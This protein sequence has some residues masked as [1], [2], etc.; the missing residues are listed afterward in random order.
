MTRQLFADSGQLGET[1]LATLQTAFAH[2]PVGIGVC[3]PDGSFLVANK[4]LE[5]L[6]G[7]RHEQIVGR[8]F[9]SFVH[10]EERA[11]CLAAYFISVVGAQT[12]PAHHGARAE[13]RF[14]T[15]QGN[16]VWLA[17]DWAITRP[18]EDGD[19]YGIVH[20]C[21]ITERREIERQ[22]ARARR[23]F[24]LAFDCAPI[25]IAVIGT[26]GR[27]VQANGALRTMLGYEDRE[28]EQTSFAELC[29]PSERAATL[30][31]FE[32]LVSGDLDMHE[33]VKRFRHLAGHTLQTRQV[34]A[35]AREP[36]GEDYLLV[37]IED[38]STGRHAAARLGEL[39]V[40]DPAT[41]LPT[42]RV[43]AAQLALTLH[44]P[45]SLVLIR[46][47]EPPDPANAPEYEQVLTSVGA[48]LTRYC[49]DGDLIAR[50]G[51]LEFAVV[52]E[53]SRATA[54]AT[55]AHR[56]RAALSRPIGSGR[57]ATKLKAA[58]SIDIDRAGTR[59]LE[60]MLQ[61]ARQADPLSATQPRPLANVTMLGTPGRALALD[62][63]LAEALREGQ[64]HLAYQPI[65]RVADRR[66]H[67]LEALSRWQHPALGAISPTEFI[68]IAERSSAIHTLT[69]WALET[70]C[71]DLVNWQAAH[72][73]AAALSVS[74][75][76]SALSFAR[77]DFPDVVNDCLTRTSLPAQQLILEIT[78]TA[79]AE[80]A[81]VLLG[82][83]LRLRER[84]VRIA[85]DDFGAGYS[86]LSRISRLPIT[87]LK[88]DQTLTS[89]ATDERVSIALLHATVRLAT[90]LELT[91][92]A[93]GI[94]SQ[95]QLD[96]LR[97]CHCP[98]AQGNL[99]AP[100]QAAA[101]ID[102]WLTAH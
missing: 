59:L 7:R 34:I 78:E 28:L 42:E 81:A 2:A 85:L 17:V 76:I 12:E 101:D 5:N 1:E 45:R 95:R 10:P 100:P 84:G 30:R 73:A 99:F 3:D 16:C 65:V 18:N 29:H 102:R 69:S 21:D 25:G 8:P 14:L 74:V 60:E 98:Y 56:I 40:R 43:L 72:P 94:E 79:A 88:L 80:P 20:F 90:D 64:L 68:P 33:S 57:G 31:V 23:H 22:L 97:R 92:I 93:E 4:A 39:G 47:P 61:N 96:L 66:T 41:G 38:I 67:S 26:D 70:A 58:V 51:E 82:N 75:N 89:A 13:V 52:V 54:G 48:L 83:A 9:L 15:G 24:K 36:D 63:D 55:M 19:Q 32:Q 91:L 71:S 44:T 11:A 49:R 87:E 77:R 86:S 27:I 46:L 6:L 62:A 50:V 53:D 35:A 37:Q